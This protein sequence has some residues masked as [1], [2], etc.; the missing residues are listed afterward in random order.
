MSSSDDYPPPGVPLSTYPLIQ[1]T[2]LGACLEAWPVESGPL[3]AKLIC[4]SA[5]GMGDE[6]ETAFAT[7]YER[8]GPEGPHGVA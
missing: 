7:I 1:S 5:A 3:P 4:N 8:P 6:N 2:A